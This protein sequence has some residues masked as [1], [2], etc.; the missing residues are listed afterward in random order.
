[1]NK[2]WISRCHKYIVSEICLTSSMFFDPEMYKMQSNVKE[3]CFAICHLQGYFSI[4]QGLYIPALRVTSRGWGD[5]FSR[6]GWSPSREESRSTPQ[7]IVLMF[8]PSA[9]ISVWLCICITFNVVEIYDSCET[10]EKN[11]HCNTVVF[12][13]EKWSTASAV[14]FRATSGPIWYGVLHC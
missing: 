12:M 14:T 1:M 9:P 6:E 2:T 10:M 3:D 11:L 8:P 13:W 7:A 5:W 4:H